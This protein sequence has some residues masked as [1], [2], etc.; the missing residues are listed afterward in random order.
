MNTPEPDP[1]AAQAAPPPPAPLSRT[2]VLTLVAALLLAVSGLFAVPGALFSA[3]YYT[4]T[5]AVV[6]FVAPMLTVSMLV[7]AAAA[8]A[9]GSRM[10]LLLVSVGTVLY[11]VGLVWLGLPASGGL[12][13]TDGSGRLWS[14]PAQLGLALVTLALAWWITSRTE[15]RP[16]APLVLVALAPVLG[17]ISGTGPYWDV[18]WLPVLFVALGIPAVLTILAAGLVCLPDRGPQIAGAALIVLAGLAVHGSSLVLGRQP[19][20]YQLVVMG[21]ALVCAVAG[22]LAR[23]RPVADGAEP[24]P[25]PENTGPLDEAAPDEAA[26][27]ASAAATDAEV[28]TMSDT[29]VVVGPSSHIGADEERGAG[30]SHVP[31]RTRTLTLTALMVLV[32]TVALNVPRM[33]AH[34]PGIQP[35]GGGMVSLTGLLVDVSLPT[36]FVLAAGAATLAVRSVLLAA[37]VLAGVLCLALLVSRAAA[38]DTVALSEGLPFVAL[39][40]S[41]ALA[42]TGVLR[43]GVGSI[44]WRWLAVVPLVLAAPAIRLLTSPGVTVYASNPAFVPQLVLPI[45]VSGLGPLLAAALLS[46]PHRRTRIAAAA[47]L[48]AVAI[49]AVVGTVENA[50]VGMRLLTALSLLQVVGYAVTC[51]LV[52]RMTLAPRAGR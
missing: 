48:G 42:W 29:A 50:A 11:L 4:N 14:G 33:F 20:P 10:F 16:W 8:V 51:V 44:A 21:L 32:L 49:A 18:A 43:P 37:T 26:P 23:P 1:R 34:G 6:A 35:S 31:G 12:P 41:V 5:W 15:R 28:I 36:A 52:V 17:R 19:L 25:G 7:L 40:L 30:R 27:G 13:T 47:L 22:I 39:G 46:Y 38:G 45:L 24:H 9:R 2:S 3:A